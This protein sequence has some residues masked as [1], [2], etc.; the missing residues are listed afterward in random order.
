VTVKRRSQLGTQA[1]S[2]VPP[3]ESHPHSV[4]RAARAPKI[5]P[6]GAA[7]AGFRAPASSA[8]GAASRA[9]TSGI[10]TANTA[11]IVVLP[12]ALLFAECDVVRPCAQDTSEAPALC[13]TPIHRSA[14]KV[15]STR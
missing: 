11:I 8:A 3:P 2:R 14:W 7:Y 1:V 4:A 13:F 5:V 6:T 15:N 9:R 10:R 12:L